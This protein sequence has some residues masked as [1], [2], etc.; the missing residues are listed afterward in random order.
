MATT[1]QIRKALAKIGGTWDEKYDCLDAPPFTQWKATHAHSIAVVYDPD[2]PAPVRWQRYLDDIR[3]GTYPCDIEDCE[4][5]E[6]TRE[7][8]AAKAHT[9]NPEG[10]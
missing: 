8:L 1:T 6:E 5:C 9:D 7:E 4:F 3:E 2:E 10:R